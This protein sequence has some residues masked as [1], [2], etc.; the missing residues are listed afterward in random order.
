VASVNSDGLVRG[1]YFGTAIII[2]T[3]VEG[4]HTATC[5]VIVTDTIM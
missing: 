5:E 1:N 3:S 4:G 2:A